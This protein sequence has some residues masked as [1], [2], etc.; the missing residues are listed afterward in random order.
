M[1]VH[2]EGRDRNLAEGSAQGHSQMPKKAH[3]KA[4]QYQLLS[5]RGTCVREEVLSI[6]STAKSLSMNAHVFVGVYFI[7]YQEK[8]VQKGNSSH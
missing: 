3:N 8:D 1:A 7:N 4:Q 2:M 5:G 6:E